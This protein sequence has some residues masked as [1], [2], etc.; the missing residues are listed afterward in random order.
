MTLCEKL[1]SEGYAISAPCPFCGADLSQFPLFSLL[2]PVHSE[3]YLLVKLNK[4]HFL[5]GDN[6][7]EVR[8]IKCGASSGRDTSPR[9]AIDKWN[10]R[11]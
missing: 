5:G 1:V 4:G 7:Y 8:C 6:G 2:R 3:E 10:T 9:V 11:P